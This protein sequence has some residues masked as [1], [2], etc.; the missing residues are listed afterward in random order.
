LTG[1]TKS[2]HDDPRAGDLKLTASEIAARNAATSAAP[3]ALN[4]FIDSAVD[5]A[6]PESSGEHPLV[7]DCLVDR[8]PEV[9]ID[10]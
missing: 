8:G 5:D 6:N 10:A 7:V 1:A 4:W 9:E 2:D 3:V